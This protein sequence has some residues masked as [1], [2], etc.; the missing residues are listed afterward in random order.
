MEICTLHSA[1]YDKTICVIPTCRQHLVGLFFRIL[2]ISLDDLSFLFTA[3]N[4]FG[5][6]NVTIEMCGMSSKVL[7]YMIL[8]VIG[9]ATM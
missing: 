3:Y 4:D 2:R 6:R 5:C 7:L 9:V 8:I 1:I